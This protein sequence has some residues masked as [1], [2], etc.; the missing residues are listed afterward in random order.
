MERRITED[1]LSNMVFA[2]AQYE[3]K[4]FENIDSKNECWR[5]LVCID[6][7]RNVFVKSYKS[8]EDA[9]EME[10]DLEEKDIYVIGHIYVTYD[11]WEERVRCSHDEI[12]LDLKKVAEKLNTPNIKEVI[13]RLKE[14][15]KSMDNVNLVSKARKYAKIA[16]KGQTR[17]DGTPFVAHPFRVAENVRKYALN[18]D[19]TILEVAAYL[20]DTVE[21]TDV[22]IDEI[23]NLFGSE[24][25]KL[26]LEVT[27]DDAMKNKLGKTAYL[28]EKMLHMS[29]DGLFLKLCDRLDNISDLDNTE[30]E[31]RM[32]YSAETLEVLSNVVAVRKLKMEHLMVV[33]EIISRMSLLKDLDEER[34]NRIKCLNLKILDVKKKETVTN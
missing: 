9:E 14:Y 33:Q 12:G 18:R 19:T 5:E 27:N 20:H 26:V 34:N 23:I 15:A 4:R 31:F 3:I 28:S 17:L 2:M 16:H 10:K 30:V 21:D 24:V 29:D 8:T 6:Y 25:G 1:N 22:T 13:K 32:R 11:E 7:E